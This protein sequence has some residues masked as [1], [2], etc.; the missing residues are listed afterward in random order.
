[1]YMPD[2]QKDPADKAENRLKTKVSASKPTAKQP[3]SPAK[4]EP[5]KSGSK[6]T[7][8]KTAASPAE[9]A[10]KSGLKSTAKKS[11]AT[12]KTTASVSETTTV[13]PKTKAVTPKTK[14]V[15]DKT[16]AVADKYARTIKSAP[17]P[18][19]KK[20]SVA[21]TV[22]ETER[23]EVK[24]DRKTDKS[25]LKQTGTKEKPATKNPKS[26]D[27]SKSKD[28]FDASSKKTDVAVADKPDKRF[29]LSMALSVLLLAGLIVALVF[30]VRA[31]LY[32]G[33]PFVATYKAATA[34]GFYSEDLGTVK[35]NIPAEADDEGLPQ[36]Y[37]KYGYTQ[38]LTTEEKNAVIAESAYLCAKPTWH[39]SG[40][41]STYTKMDKD[42]NL[43]NADG[44]RALDKNNQPRKLYK[45]SASVGLYMGDVSD[46]EP[47]VIKRLTLAPRGYSSYGVTGLYA[48]AG[49][50][51]KIEISE[52]D[53]DATGGITV[54]IGQAL[55]NGQAN[56]IWSAK[57]VNRMPV[58][59]NTMNVDK[60]TAEYSDGVY[61][62]Y[63]GSYLGGPIYIR[64]ESVTFTVTVSGAVNYKHFILGSTTP[65]QF[66]EYS[67]SSAPYFD[68]EVWDHGV[69]HSGPKI[70]AEGL[71]YDDIYKAAVL[72]EKISLVS[73]RVRSQGVVFLYDP[74]VAA[75]AAVA[76]P[77]RR[78]VN[79][80]MGW[81]TGSLNYESFVKSGAW[82]NMHEYHHNFQNWGFSGYCDEVSNNALNLVSYSLFTKISESRKLGA[83][84]DGLG[85]WNRFTSAPYALRQ[86]IGKTDN[87][88]REYAV[89]LHNI[90]QDAFIRAIQ[91]YFSTPGAT[92]VDRWYKG[93]TEAT[94]NDMTYYFR[95]LLG[96]SVSDEVVAEAQAKNYPVFVPVST[97]YQTGRSYQ[98]D[99]KR[100]YITTM[101]PYVI[102]YGKEI[103]VDLEKY[104]EENGMYVSGSLVVPNGFSYEIKTV[105]NP[106]NGS[107][108]R[109]SGTNK[110]T[111]KPNENSASGKIYVRLGITKDDRAFEVDDVKLVLEFAQSHEMNKTML[112]RTT[113]NYDGKVYD[114]ATAAYEAGYAGYSSKD[115]GD[116]VNPVQNSNT[117]VWYTSA[118]PE[119]S[120]VEVRGKIYVE[121]DGT[122]RL[123][124]R[125]RYNCALYASLDGE[126]YELAATVVTEGTSANFLLTEGTY[127][128][129][130]DLKAGQWVYIKAVL[131]NRTTP[132]ISYIGVGWGMHEMLGGTIDEDGNQITAPETIINVKYASAYRS[133][134]EFPENEFEAD[135]FYTREYKE[136]YSD[137]R[138]VETKQSL[139]DVK[140]FTKFR[141]L[142]SGGIT[143]T[144]GIE[145]LFDGDDDNNTH[146]SGAVSSDNPFELT[147][148]L[149]NPVKA[150][151]I[152]LHGNTRPSGGRLF[153][154]V[155]FDLYLSE[156]GENYTKAG[157]YKDRPI[158]NS[159]VV[160]DFEETTFS[161][162]RIVVTRTSNNSSYIALNKISFASAVDLANGNKLSPYDKKFEFKGDWKIQS[163]PSSFGNVFVGAGGAVLD[164]EFKGNR[165][166]ILSSSLFGSKFEVEIDGKRA[167]SIELKTDDGITVMSYISPDMG[168]TEHTVRIRCSGE[169][170]ID[171]IVVW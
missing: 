152:V 74:F 45:H 61:T 7:A 44:S 62:A 102:E 125:G 169:A 144:Y 1:M 83:S 119:N 122:Y 132:R 26:S 21:A 159:Q 30:G 27:K 142:Q 171:S 60:S 138:P 107:I 40:S 59:L 149:E 79:C 51:I 95:D 164:F 106:E 141:D 66:E 33:E 43:Y 58:I 133:D 158:S 84:G 150:N 168:N 49:E 118:P 123:A 65:E 38:S 16:K 151:R 92:A 20:A 127:R 124:L 112:Q 86:V 139:V 39:A 9:S 53:M 36:G 31:C 22:A 96:Y 81:M 115:D 126:N 29:V 110:F 37:P 12:P 87:G 57:N 77:G 148:A 153:I 52:K 54:H 67:K 109:I 71:D 155:D 35:R 23:P 78:S 130:A 42:G 82:G 55:Y 163:A 50:V 156:D 145:N 161:Y 41:G 76:F 88:L 113:Y 17:A 120:I 11:A 89:L 157:E 108:T 99:G 80:P 98:Y 68:L 34:V 135:Y 5:A 166:G 154:P 129:Y 19:D 97:I 137:S 56:N 63:V 147:A 134:Y 167:D 111:F 70:Y 90:G 8:K 117:D 13:I 3:V 105:T 114:S 101:R 46:D 85:G 162:Y 64:N 146:S 4:T 72:W 14:S 100:K 25:G 28:F 94:H 48:P 47:G 143:Y 170:N 103:T 128:D 73:N 104:T 15:A 136:S 121:E 116:N 24:T 32:I 10:A 165:I 131:L 140:G 18:K 6:P 75:G 2:K 91:N 93:L 69:L 160:A